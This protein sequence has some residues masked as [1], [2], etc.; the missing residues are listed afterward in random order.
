MRYWHGGLRRV[1]LASSTASDLLTTESQVSVLAMDAQYLYYFDAQT[2]KRVAKS[3][4]GPPV[5]LSTLPSILRS[6]PR[7]R[8]PATSRT[9]GL[10]RRS[11]RPVLDREAR[12]SGELAFVTRRRNRC[13]QS[14]RSVSYARAPRPNRNAS[15]AKLFS[16]YSAFTAT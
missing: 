1:D 11:L 7:C 10:Q 2:L 15:H 4:G 5:V 9:A 6:S 14:P 13:A 3:G 8:H 16:A 12:D